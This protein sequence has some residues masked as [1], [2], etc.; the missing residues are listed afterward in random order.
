MDQSNIIPITSS[1]QIHKQQNYS[2]QLPFSPNKIYDN[3]YDSLKSCLS[4]MQRYDNSGTLYDVYRTKVLLFTEFNSNDS[5]EFDVIV[6][7]CQQCGFNVRLPFKRCKTVGELKTLYP[8]PPSNGC[9]VK[10]PRDKANFNK[11]LEEFKNSNV[12]TLWIFRSGKESAGLNFPFVDTLIEYSRFK[13]HKQI[14][15]RVKRLNRMIPVDIIRLRYA[16]KSEIDNYVDPDLE[17][18][19]NNLTNDTSQ[20]TV[21]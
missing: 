20:L 21:R 9:T 10:H 4:T 11:D 2:F 1:T 14:I 12:R 19:V 7:L 17:D 5:A 8:P 15:G 13:A 18:D 6:R 16:S 3:K